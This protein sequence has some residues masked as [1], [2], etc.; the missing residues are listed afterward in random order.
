MATSIQS[1]RLREKSIKMIQISYMIYLNLQHAYIQCMYVIKSPIFARANP[2]FC[3]RSFCESKKGF[4]S[5]QTFSPGQSSVRQMGQ[6]SIGLSTTSRPGNS[7]ICS[8]QVT[9]RIQGQGDND[10]CLCQSQIEYVPTSG[11]K[12]LINLTHSQDKSNQH[13][14]QRPKH[15][16]I[17][18]SNPCR[19]FPTSTPEMDELSFLSLKIS[20]STKCNNSYIYLPLNLTSKKK[21]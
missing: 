2:S 11:P 20:P 16:L 9:H 14:L 8:R 19:H 12:P 5:R 18:V 15:R 10:W 1:S 17:F 4:P 7:A 21:M 6:S 3:G 13:D